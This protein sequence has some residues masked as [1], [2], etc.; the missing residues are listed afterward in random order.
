MKKKKKKK[1]N[2][3]IYIYVCMYVFNLIIFALFV[4]IKEKPWYSVKKIENNI[5]TTNNNKLK[6][7]KKE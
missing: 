3:Y 6:Q 1:K 2:I 4:I 5:E 7:I